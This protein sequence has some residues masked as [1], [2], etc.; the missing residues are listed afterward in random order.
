MVCLPQLEED[1]HSKNSSSNS[2]LTEHI[3]FA[4]EWLVNSFESLISDIRNLPLEMEITLDFFL[5]NFHKCGQKLWC[6][7]HN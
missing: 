2:N 7:Y 6:V 3:Y 4:C 1:P 5:F